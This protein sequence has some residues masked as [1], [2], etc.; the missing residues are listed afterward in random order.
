M[1]SKCPHT[2]TRQTFQTDLQQQGSDYLKAATTSAAAGVINGC[3]PAAE[4]RAAQ[5][6]PHP[7]VQ[8]QGMSNPSMLTSSRPQSLHLLKR[9]R[10]CDLNHHAG[11]TQCQVLRPHPSRRPRTVAGLA[12]SP[13]T[14]ARTP[15]AGSQTGAADLKQQ[16]GGRPQRFLH[17]SIRHAAAL[18]IGVGQPKG[19]APGGLP[20]GGLREQAALPQQ[21][22]DPQSE[23]QPDC[24]ADGGPP[25]S[26]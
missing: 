18:H 14:Q 23:G 1:V 13:I 17:Q 6:R 9:G 3:S 24:A 2:S 16:C 21:H 5:R 11:P 12:T 7:A 26:D 19:R 15:A 10:P 20:H 22:G 8:Q 4:A 25:C